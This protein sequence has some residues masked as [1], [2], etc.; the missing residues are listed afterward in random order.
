MEWWYTNVQKQGG[1][2]QLGKTSSCSQELYLH[3]VKKPKTLPLPLAQ[4]LLGRAVADLSRD[5]RAV[6]Q[7]VPRG[8]KRLQRNLHPSYLQTRPPDQNPADGGVT[9]RKACTNAT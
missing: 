3:T 2:R 8:A 1:K 7:A 9:P 6:P 4:L 5:A